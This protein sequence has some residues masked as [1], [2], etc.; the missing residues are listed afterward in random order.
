MTGVSG[1]GKST[2]A[3]EILYKAAKRALGNQDGRPGQ[4]T[5]IMG[6]DHIEDVVLVDQRAIGRTPRANALTYTK[7]LDPIR[8]LLADTSEAQTGGLGP[9]HFSF[10]VAGGR[11]ETCKGEGFEKVEMQFL[12]DVYIT[13]P[14]CNGKRFKADVL[15]IRYRERNI[16]D[17]LTMT[18]DQALSFFKDHKKVVAALQPLNDVGLGY[19]RLGQ[20]INTMSG[21]EAQR[22]KLSRYVK[23]DS[24]D[25]AP[26][27]FIFDEPTTG[28]HF[29]DIAKLLAALQRLVE[30]GNTVLVI[31]HNMD[32]VKTA[33][34]VID[35]GPD[36]GD[37][38]GRVATKPS[39]PA[40]T[41]A[42]SRRNA[43]I[44]P[45]RDATAPV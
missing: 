43:A 21:G 3:E 15:N 28:L 29:D 35:L 12:S 36:G 27:L 38:G 4:H 41:S 17:I 33:D 1:S 42:S 7:A 5:A 20:P 24:V 26:K 34:W 9:G 6:L 22:L 2:L 8:R 31:E 23:I 16:H 10:N 13:C 11:C 32:V 18:V 25:A 37:A 45:R 30:S 44:F 14:D 19:I 39:L 40:T